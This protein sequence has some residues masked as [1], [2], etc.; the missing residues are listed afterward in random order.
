MGSAAAL[1]VEYPLLQEMRQRPAV[2]WRDVLA[3]IHFN[4]H[5]NGEGAQ[6]PLPA[7]ENIPIAEV[8]APM[9]AGADSAA[10][11]WRLSGPMRSGQHGRV[12]YRHNGRLLFA[13]LS[14]SEHE[15][16][17]AG[18]AE[19]AH[20]LRSAT[21]AGY[22]ELFNTIESLH[23]PHP[24]RIWNFLPAINGQSE[25]G[26]RYWHFNGA[27]QD[28]FLGFNRCI[29]GNVPAASAVGA[30]SGAPLTIYCIASAS[31]P[32]SLENPRQRAAWAYPS[33]Y[34]PRSP[35]F[36]RACIEGDNA[37]TLFISGTS[38]IVGHETAH[39]GDESEQTRETLRNIRA[40]IA[41][42]NERIGT[43]RFTL[44]DLH[45]KVYVRHP[46][47]LASI[48]RELRCEIGERPQVMFLRADICRRE[49]LVEIEAV[50][51]MVAG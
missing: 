29:S 47:H 17:D 38:S 28:V 37:H 46:A 1:Q 34:G 19:S 33:Q 48:E 31:A 14:I 49:L 27:R 20:A 43:Q 30:H 21:E 16:S 12:N 7:A 2:W 23:F 32:I 18:S 39:E 5:V 25:G 26:E 3:L 6:P 22:S 10:E 9:L 41:A 51:T 24:L 15:F 11:V 13:A 44:S 35:T 45:Y 8:S 42:A 4:G 40:M 36:A 50:G